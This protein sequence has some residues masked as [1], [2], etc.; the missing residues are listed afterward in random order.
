STPSA[1]FAGVEDVFVKW[2]WFVAASNRTRS[3]KVPPTSTPRR[4]LMG[5]KHRTPETAAAWR[6]RSEDAGPA[7]QPA[8][9]G[10]CP[11]RHGELGRPGARPRGALRGRRRR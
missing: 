1:W 3:V 10:T 6:L 11:C 4:T 5:G 8:R 7:G 2:I 9:R